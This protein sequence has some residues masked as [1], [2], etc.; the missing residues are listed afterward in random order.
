MIQDKLVENPKGEPWQLLGPFGPLYACLMESMTEEKKKRKSV[1]R[2]T[3]NE[4]VAVA[5]N[6]GM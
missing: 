3:A 2:A 6:T 1:D 4:V 5:K